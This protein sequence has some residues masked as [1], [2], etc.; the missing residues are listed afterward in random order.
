MLYRAGVGIHTYWLPILVPVGFVGNILSIL[1]MTSKQNIKISCCVYMSILAIV[2]NIM[3]CVA[4]EFWFVIIGYPRNRYIWEC[5]MIDFIFNSMNIYG[6]FLLIF[7][8]MGNMDML[9]ECTTRATDVVARKEEAEVID[10][11]QR[12]I[13]HIL[14]LLEIISGVHK[15]LLRGGEQCTHT[16]SFFIKQG[17][18]YWRK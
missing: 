14:R 15:S 4:T 3:L 12:A 2:D 6:V 1:V 10:L 13:A 11:P 7:R 16:R 9:L 18:S 5:K 17:I 8:I